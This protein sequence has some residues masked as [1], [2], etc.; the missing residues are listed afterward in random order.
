MRNRQKQRQL[1]KEQAKHRDEIPYRNL[2]HYADPTAYHA[3]R[4]I[5]REERHPKPRAEGTTR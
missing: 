3:L 2:E 5:E 1:K 4:N